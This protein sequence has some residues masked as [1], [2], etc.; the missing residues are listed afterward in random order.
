LRIALKKLKQHVIS[1]GNMLILVK[2]NKGEEY[3]F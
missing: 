1:F 2:F 3:D